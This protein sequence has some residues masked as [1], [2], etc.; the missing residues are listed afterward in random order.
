MTMAVAR[1]AAASPL[2]DA[3]ARHGEADVAALRPRAQAQ[4]HAKDVAARCTLGAIYARRSDLPRAALYLADCEHADLPDDIAAVVQRT[5]RDV[6]RRLDASQ[7]A[8]LDIVTRTDGLTAEID[9]L[10]GE[11][12]TTPVTV[13][14]PAGE[15]IIRVRDGDRTWTR[16][17]T[18]EPHRNGVVMVETEREARPAAPRT[19]AID[20]AQDDPGAPIEQHTGPPPDIKHPPLTSNKWRGIPDG[21]AKPLLDDWAVE[22]PPRPTRRP[23]WLGLRLAGGMFDDGAA[24]A[25][26][27]IA[28]GV[29]GRHR[30]GSSWFASARVDWSRRGGDAMTGAIDALGAGAGFGATLV[31]G[32]PGELALAL[33]GQL[34]GDLRLA[35]QRNSDP[36]RRA[37]LGIAVGAELALPSSPFTAGLRFEQGVTE[38]VAGVR[39]RALLVELGVDLR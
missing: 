36:V 28:V 7:L 29:A 30:L 32:F 16:R 31:G 19:V 27:G 24:D 15:R 3:L 13:W 25:R 23:Y 33:I 20:F 8:G 10:P 34:R 6:K 17:V 12:L 26:A 37:G 39:D 1:S 38:L 22:H 35:D 5:V 14:V 9:A 21:T 18:A 4:A 2:S 11:A